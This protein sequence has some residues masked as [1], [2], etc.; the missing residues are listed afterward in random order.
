VDSSIFDA[1]STNGTFING[2]RIVYKKKIPLSAGQRVTI[3][4]TELFVEDA[5][6]E[7]IGAASDAINP[8]E[9][10]SPENPTVE[11]VAQE[12]GSQSD[13]MREL[14]DDDSSSSGSSDEDVHE[15]PPLPP[16]IVS[17]GTNTGGPSW[18]PPLPTSKTMR[19]SSRPTPSLILTNN[20]TT[21]VR[22]TCTMVGGQTPIVVGG[23]T[24][25]ESNSKE[26]EHLRAS[27]NELEKQLWKSQ[28]TNAQLRTK[29]SSQNRRQNLQ[30]NKLKV[31]KYEGT[32]KSLEHQ[33]YYGD[34][35]KDKELNKLTLKFE[36]YQ[37]ETQALKNG[38]SI[39][40]HSQQVLKEVHAEKNAISA[41][42]KEVQSERD[43]LQ[44]EVAA[45]REQQRISEEEVQT[46]QE[47]TKMVKSDKDSVRIL[48]TMIQDVQAKLQYLIFT[49][50]LLLA[51]TIFPMWP[52]NFPGE[53]N[54]IS[55][56]ENFQVSLIETFNFE[57]L[58]FEHLDFGKIV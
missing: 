50:V 47:T 42:L 4:Q 29:L 25:V 38:A 31:Q 13:A 33:L 2:E 28:Q 37:K 49:I 15:E 1:S 55:I 8:T 16:S 12:N 9:T 11:E 44:I 58:T 26:E 40:A 46:K 17:N 52:E 3:G 27:I 56:V 10:V 22:S 30:A 35:E 43:Q 18:L 21:P 24:P 6:V 53:I 36:A 7:V 41:S 57:N 48:S 39:A 54:I 32:I 5:P 19:P 45:L 23:Q 20:H 14:A 34:S 51:L